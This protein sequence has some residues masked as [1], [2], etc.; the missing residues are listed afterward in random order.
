M[1]ARLC[2]QHSGTRI[3]GE[4]EF[5]SGSGQMAKRGLG[6]V[7]GPEEQGL[8]KPR[9]KQATFS[10]LPEHT[11]AG[12]WDAAVRG[13]DPPMGPPRGTPKQKATPVVV[14]A[15]DSPC[16]DAALPGAL[17][18]WLCR[19]HHPGHLCCEF[20]MFSSVA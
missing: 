8:E 4:R 2:L 20:C 16:P 9:G 17:P 11:P 12:P 5:T 13:A 19:C 18:A 10:V 15:G 3:A 14:R 7:N 6:H 1:A